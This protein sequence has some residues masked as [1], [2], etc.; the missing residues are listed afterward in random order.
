MAKLIGSIAAAALLVAIAVPVLGAGPGAAAD[1]IA[2]PNPHTPQGS[3]WYYHFDRAKGRKCWYVGPQARKVQ[4][5][6]TGDL[7]PRVQPTAVA[8]APQTPEAVSNRSTPTPVEPPPIKALTAV[9]TIAPEEASPP[10]PVQATEQAP[11]RTP[12]D[13]ERTM[14]AVQETDAA[15]ETPEPGSAAETADPPAITP[16]RMLVLLAGALAVATILLGL[17]FTLSP[18]RRGLRRQYETDLAVVIAAARRAAPPLPPA[19]SL[20]D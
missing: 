17:I 7:A 14:S 8:I 19:S 16:A 18:T 10:T 5:E 20:S 1:C 4:G 6:V 12:G 15:H 9:G 3:H 11:V 13:Q 2:A